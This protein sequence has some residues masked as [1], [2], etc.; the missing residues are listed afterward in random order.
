MGVYSLHDCD[1]TKGWP[2]LCLC[3]SLSLSL[4]LVLVWSAPNLLDRPE[5]VFTCQSQVL[6]AEFSKFNPNIIVG[7]TYSGQLAMWDTR[8]KSAPVQVC[9][10][11]SL[12]SSTMR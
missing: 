2:L 9:K 1:I 11:F 3:L 4:R 10:P 5:F 6:K 8:A 12:Y 7:G